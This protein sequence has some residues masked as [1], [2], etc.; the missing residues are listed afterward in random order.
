M[1]VDA[2][3]EAHHNQQLNNH[4]NN[5]NNPNPNIDEEPNDNNNALDN[6]DN[7]NNENFQN[8]IELVAAAAVEDN[9]LGEGVIDGGIA[10]MPNDK[11]NSSSNNNNNN[12]NNN[13]RNPSEPRRRTAD[14]DLIIC[15]ENLEALVPKLKV[16]TKISIGM[17]KATK[18]GKLIEQYIYNVNLQSSHNELIQLTEVEFVHNDIFSYEDVRD[19]TADQCALM[20]G[21]VVQV[22]RNRSVERAKLAEIGR[23]QEEMDRTYF[24]DLKCGLMDGEWAD[25]TL[26]CRGTVNGQ[27]VLNTLVRAHSSVL[28]LRCDWFRDLISKQR[29]VAEEVRLERERNV[30]PAICIEEEMPLNEKNDN[31]CDNDHDMDH[32]FMRRNSNEASPGGLPKRLHAD[33]SNHDSSSL[34]RREVSHASTCNGNKEAVVVMQDDEEM[35]MATPLGYSCYN[36]INNH[37]SSNNYNNKLLRVPIVHH[38]PGVVKLLLEF[39]YTNRCVPL[40]YEAF[41]AGSRSRAVNPHPVPRTYS[42]YGNNKRTAWPNRGEPM[43]TMDMALAAITLG[44]EAGVNQFTLMCEVAA[45]QLITHHNVLDALS[46]CTSQAHKSGNKLNILRKSAASYLL[47][48]PVLDELSKSRLFLKN[49]TEKREHVVPALL[50]GTRESVVSSGQLLGAKNGNGSHS[51]SNQGNNQHYQHRADGNGNAGGTSN[52][53]N[54]SSAERNEQM[55]QYQ[56]FSQDASDRMDRRLEREKW[57]N[58]NSGIQSVNAK[59]GRWTEI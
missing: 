31:Q 16:G 13:N 22:R 9:G 41:V 11:S 8:D 44:E 5:N 36:N 12:N 30:Q 19:M 6:D 48:K 20:K 39:L 32:E 42:A 52:R 21:D 56:F 59:K 4:N 2:Q 58:E 50:H 38:S 53:R 49:L 18:I 15:I 14:C 33:I 17:E 29:I 7:N 34:P 10:Y 45:S 24:Q 47:R 26:D 57:R 25:I 37:S 35:D 1:D 28:S 23:R 46:K 51:S 27:E 43:L 55:M 54:N 40:G 3:P